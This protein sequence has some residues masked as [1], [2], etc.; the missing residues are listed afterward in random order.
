MPSGE[1]RIE[2]LI[3]DLDFLDVLYKSLLPE[4]KEFHTKRGRMDIS[5]EHNKLVILIEGIDLS[6]LRALVNS[7]LRLIGATLDTL[8]CLF[9]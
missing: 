6:I 2:L 4:L 9:R 3:E 7:A 5:R 8:Y 1:V